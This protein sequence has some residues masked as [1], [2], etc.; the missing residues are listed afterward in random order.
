MNEGEAL[1]ITATFSEVISGTP[2]ISINTVGTDLAATAM[3]DSGDQTVWTF[4]YIV[5]TASTGFATVTISGTDLAGNSNDA[6]TNN[7][8]TIG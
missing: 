1:T 3:D 7:V 6:A 5:P 4:D 8:L 2:T